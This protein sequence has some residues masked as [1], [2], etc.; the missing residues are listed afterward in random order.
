MTDDAG[1]TEAESARFPVCHRSS[2]LKELLI[3]RREIWLPTLWGWLGL[4]LILCC[5]GAI[6]ALNAEAY[7]AVNAARPDATVLVVEGWIGKM[8]MREAKIEFERGH[9][10]RIVTAGG[11]GEDLWAETVYSDAIR[12]RQEMMSQ[13]VP[14][15]RILAADCGDVVS[16]RTFQ[17]AQATRR[18]LA[19]Q[20]WTK[21]VVNVFTRGAHARRSRMVF[22][23]ALGKD[24]EVGCTAW[25]PEEV[26]NTSWWRSSQR[27]KDL[28]TEA[29]GYVYEWLANSGRR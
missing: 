9:Y 23:K 21:G 26:R 6:L 20:G 17:A 1:Q 18:V 10:E 4:V 3:R 22:A 25:M 11:A 16:G 19:E 27:T 15:D 5:G 7:L 28:M 8:G 2:K 24:I 12:A 13:G 29:A 14:A